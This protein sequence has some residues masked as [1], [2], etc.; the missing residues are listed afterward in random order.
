MYAR[1]EPCCLYFIL[2]GRGGGR[3]GGRAGRRNQGGLG[4]S[5]E[6]S[7]PLFSKGLDFPP[8]IVQTIKKIFRTYFA[9]LAHIYYHHYNE[10]LKLGAH[11]GLNTLLLHL[12]YFVREFSL[13]DSKELACLEELVAKLVKV[14]EEAAKNPKH[15]DDYLEYEMHSAGPAAS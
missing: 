8:D 13:M 12:V 1:V 6:L 3:V 4:M 9:I 2:L 5:C 11:R 7:P 10:L 15:D 14:E